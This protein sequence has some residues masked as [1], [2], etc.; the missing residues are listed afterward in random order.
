[1]SWRNLQKLQKLASVSG[2]GGCFKIILIS[3]RTESKLALHLHIHYGEKE[4]ETECVC[5]H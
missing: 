3:N 4:R 1:M 5:L 2:P